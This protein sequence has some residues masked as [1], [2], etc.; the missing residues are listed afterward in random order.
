MT[1]S[2]F[3]SSASTA[4]KSAPLSDTISWYIKHK[5]ALSR[6]FGVLGGVNAFVGKFNEE[7]SYQPCIS[8]EA[9]CDWLTRQMTIFD[10]L[11]EISIVW[12]IL[13][14]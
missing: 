2:V 4:P 12:L 8:V 1:S 3:S 14:P 9:K 11:T 6:Y 5:Y 10:W 13:K 7:K